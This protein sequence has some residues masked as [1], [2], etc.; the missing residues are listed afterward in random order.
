[1]N[2][3]YRSLL[4]SVGVIVTI[5]VLAYIILQ[6][7]KYEIPFFLAFL[8]VMTITMVGSLALIVKQYLKKDKV[9]EITEILVVR[10]LFLIPFII[11]LVVGILMNK[12]DIV[13]FA[14]LFAVYYVIFA[15]TETRTMMKLTNKGI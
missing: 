2:K 11:L 8:P 7:M 1:M 13:L 15:V 6:L 4:I 12:N 14:I 5:T 9:L 3:I 10:I